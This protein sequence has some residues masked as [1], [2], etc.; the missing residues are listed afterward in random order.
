[1]RAIRGPTIPTGLLS[2]PTRPPEHRMARMT[3]A[4]FRFACSLLALFVLGTC[5][6]RPPAPD[7]LTLKPVAF[8]D[9]PGWSADDQAA[10]VTAPRRTCTRFAR[11]SEIGRA[12]V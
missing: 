4:R 2:R 8:S 11:Q 9:L 3:A 10:A 1:M 6:P 5:A 7:R 12:H